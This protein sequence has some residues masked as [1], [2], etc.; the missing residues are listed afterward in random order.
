MKKEIFVLEVGV[1]LNDTNN[2]F[3]CYHIPNFYDN[4]Y[5]FYD[6]NRITYFDYNSAKEYADKYIKE[7]VNKTYAIIH[8]YIVNLDDYD[9]ESINDFGYCEQALE[10][11]TL[12]TTHY[13]AYK[14]NDKLLEMISYKNFI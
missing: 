10:N 9:I 7:G 13:F 14:D 3:D 11:P 1:L 5:S 8:S 12:E 4:E 2:E 6:E